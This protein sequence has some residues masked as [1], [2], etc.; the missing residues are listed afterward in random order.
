MYN[1][2]WWGMARG[3]GVKGKAKMKKKK[4]ENWNGRDGNIGARL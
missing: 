2:I 3:G 4:M 1:K